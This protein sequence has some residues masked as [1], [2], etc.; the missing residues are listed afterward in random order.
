MA[1]GRV[2]STEAKPFGIRINACFIA[3]LSN[4]LHTFYEL[5]DYLRPRQKKNSPVNN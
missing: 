3:S 5:S 1:R 2:E 4:C